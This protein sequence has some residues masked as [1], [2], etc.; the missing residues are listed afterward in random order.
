MTGAGTEQ[1][2]Q[3]V[4]RLLTPVA[5][6][7]GSLAATVFAVD[8]DERG[9]RTWLR[10]WRGELRVRDRI[11]VGDAAPERVTALG[12]SRT[13]GL[14][15][16][17]VARPGDI[18]VVRGPSGWR[19]G[20]TIGTAPARAVRPFAP[21]T[22]QTVVEPVD[23]TQRGALFAALTE[24]ADEDPLIDLR[25][26]EDD[27]AL[28]L[29][30]EVQKEVIGAL[31]EQRFGVPARFRGTRTV[32][33][34]RVVGTGSALDEINIAGNPY[35][36]TIGLRIDAAPI[37]HG[38]EFS[39]GIERGHLPPAFIAATEEGVRAALRQGRF[40]WAV[41]DCVVTMTASHYAPRQSHAHQKFNK[42]MS[43]VGADFRRLAPVVVTAA[44]E[45]ARTR[46]C[47]PV[48]RF[49]LEFP[50]RLVSAVSALLGRLGATTSE[51][52]TSNSW[53]RYQGHVRSARVAELASR[54]PDLTG[55][56]AILQSDFDH[57]TPVTGSAPPARPR[58][59][60]DPRDRQEW[61]RAMPR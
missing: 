9:R 20:D 60:V 53:T 28:S 41:T 39:P 33:I 37:G 25:L 23:A 3:A 30:G 45:Q 19:I 29:H 1:L 18:V 35:L 24:L 50:E 38:V 44:L 31:L 56:E 17:P 58:S 61:F 34:E 57:Y 14:R 51:S 2:R 46:V 10:M 8:R 12:V 42:A 40:G 43:S 36:A 7:P 15:N 26:D 11:A 48:D 59:G 47:E 21:P 54:L 32:C 16:D 4:V 6:P 22:L 5:T 49:D 27:C 52:M 55:G 13:G